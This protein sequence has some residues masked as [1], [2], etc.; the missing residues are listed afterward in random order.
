MTFGT[1]ILSLQL[2]SQ[3]PQGIPYQAVARDL[4]GTPILNTS[5]SVRFTVHDGSGTGAIEFQETHTVTSN[6]LGV[7]TVVIG[8]GD[9]TQGTF[10]GINWADGLQFVQVEIDP[11]GGTNYLDMG[12]TQM[13][14]VPYALYAANGGSTGPTGT[15]GA[16]GPSGVD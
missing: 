11:T 6:A 14:S 10:G 16:T 4:N 12:V 2:I 15:A 5:M 9:I 13:F 3:S 8:G 7:F 1:L